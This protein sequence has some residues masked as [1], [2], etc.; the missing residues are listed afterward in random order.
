MDVSIVQEKTSIPI[1]RVLDW[2]DDPSNSVGTEYIIMEHVHGVQLQ[3][4]WPDMT[5]LQRLECV[6][7]LGNLVKQMHDLEFPAYGSIYSNDGLVNSSKSV[8][9]G[10]HFCIG[11]NSTSRYFPCYPTDHRF[12][13]RIPPNRGPCK[14]FEDWSICSD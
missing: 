4:Q 5:G 7:S 12:Y 3:Q 11:P 14:S 9:L 13:N 1:P 6:L 10:T 8:R 2:S